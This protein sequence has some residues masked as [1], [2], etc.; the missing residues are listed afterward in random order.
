MPN[1][2]FLGE[3]QVA[4][5]LIHILRWRVSFKRREIRRRRYFW[6]IRVKRTLTMY[7]KP[8]VVV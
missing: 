8:L 5:F 7:A 3:K 1:A 2:S 6:T 4:D